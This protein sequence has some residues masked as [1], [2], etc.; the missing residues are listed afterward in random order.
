MKRVQLKS[1]KLTNFK[2][3]SV[4]FIEFANFTEIQG[5]NKVGKSTVADAYIWLLEGRNQEDRA[6]FS[7]KTLDE[8]NQ[9]IPKLE[10]SVEGVF[11]VN[12]E[13]ITFKRLLKEK[14]VT[15]RGSSEEEFS[16]H[17][18]TYFFNEVPISATEYKSK[19][20]EMV[21]LSLLK[22]ISNP[23]YFN[24]K[25]DWKERRAIL[26]T[27][28]GE[29]SDD[30]ILEDIS[31]P[32]NDFFYLIQL[33]NSKKSFEDEA[34]ILSSRKTKI[35]EEL[36]P[37]KYKIEEVVNTKPEALD[38]KKIEEIKEK[39]LKELNTIEN[40][41]ESIVNSNREQQSKIVEAE[42]EKFEIEQKLKRLSEE[43]YSNSQKERRE[44]TQKKQDLTFDRDRILRQMLVIE[45]DVQ[46][47]EGIVALMVK[48]KEDLLQTWHNENNKIFKMPEGCDSCPTCKQTLPDVEGIEEKLRSEF[49]KNKVEV[50][51]KVS[52]EGKNQANLIEEYNQA[53]NKLNE[54][55]EL[56]LKECA[57]LDQAINTLKIPEVEIQATPSEEIIKLQKEIEAF[58]IPE[59]KEESSEEFKQK[60][61]LLESEIKALDSDLS[62]KDQIKKSDDRIDFLNAERK[63]L[64]EELMSFESN[65]NEILTFK[66]AKI[67]VV[68]SRVNK[69]F[70]LVKFKM[71]N[72]Q[73]NGGIEETCECLVNGIPF[74]D[75]NTAGQINSGLDVISAIQGHYQIQAPIFI[76]RS[77]S[78]VTLE[79]MDCQLVSLKVNEKEPKLIVLNLD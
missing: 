24:T 10:H 5:T 71:F 79:K 15:K 38:F 3:H 13:N 63:R 56:K 61:I 41:I 40:S 39:R 17:E 55:H 70:S 27:M 16:G 51:D 14:W 28:A 7:V 60:K 26:T 2:K 29:I 58:K 67:D 36:K 64:S 6:D 47:Q 30:L 72:T 21:D 43:N 33:L 18:T 11:N 23:L 50:L 57:K 46:K 65:E 9:S 25:I 32:E 73:I 49:N 69:M 31:T 19:V 62:I 54:D 75:V 22:L 66:S 78:V 8:N 52:A 48:S 44:A 45:N 76:D 34:K 77:E 42:K 20:S 12:D 4:L 59:I 1:L 35:K 68:E 37:L 53:I 74:S